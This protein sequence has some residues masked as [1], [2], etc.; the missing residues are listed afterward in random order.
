M[1]DCTLAL[2]WKILS[3]KLKNA[4]R[5]FHVRLHHVIKSIGKASII[6]IKGQS[7]EFATKPTRAARRLRDKSFGIC[8]IF[9]KTFTKSFKWHKLKIHPAGERHKKATT[10]FEKGL[11]TKQRYSPLNFWQ[12]KLISS[13][14]TKLFG[15]CTRQSWQENQDRQVKEKRK[16][17]WIH[18]TAVEITSS[19]Q[20]ISGTKL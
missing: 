18:F 19:L 2:A 14:L 4:A 3:R 11:E 17:K 7:R 20:I 10:R 5:N 6:T 13:F 1:Y 16:S 15:L 9:A 8:M 12:L